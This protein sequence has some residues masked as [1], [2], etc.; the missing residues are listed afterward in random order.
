MRAGAGG[1]SDPFAYR[2]TELG[3]QVGSWGVASWGRG[4][5]NWMQS[6]RQPQ[7]VAMPKGADQGCS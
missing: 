4:C 1:R 6:S 3:L 5:L 7:A 2:A